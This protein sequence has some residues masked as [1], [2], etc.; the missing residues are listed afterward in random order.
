MLPQPTG[1]L[2]IFAYASLIWNPAFEYEELRK[3]RLEGFHR[4][5]CITSIH[6]RGNEQFPGLVMGLDGGGHCDGVAY[7]VGKKQE[8]AA[9]QALFEREMLDN[10]YIPSIVPIVLDNGEKVDCLTFISNTAS[11]RYMPGL[12]QV[13]TINIVNKACGS[14]GSNYDYV[15][16]TIKKL[17]EMQIDDPLS[18]LL[19]MLS[20]AHTT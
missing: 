20:R 3:A 12:S 19:P 1:D 6:Y 11:I 5:L 10:V 17:E 13:D 16:N 15:F 8:Q 18:C 9:L 2:W 7:R 14:R 4:A